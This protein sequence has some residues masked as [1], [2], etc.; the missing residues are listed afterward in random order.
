MLIR[1]E[2]SKDKINGK[3]D[4]IRDSY[5]EQLIIQKK[6]DKRRNRLCL[7]MAEAKTIQDGVTLRSPITNG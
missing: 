3:I 6:L 7:L 5:H 1:K 4:K 2:Y